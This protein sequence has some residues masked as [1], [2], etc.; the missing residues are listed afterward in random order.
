VVADVNVPP[1]ADTD[2]LDLLNGRT[3]Q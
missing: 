2:W 3:V 1:V